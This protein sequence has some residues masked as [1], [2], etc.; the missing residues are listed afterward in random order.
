V[1]QLLQQGVVQ[2]VEWKLQGLQQGSTSSDSTFVK[3][4][5]Q[6]AELKDPLCTIS[7]VACHGARS[8]LGVLRLLKEDIFLLP[9]QLLRLQLQRIELAAK[10]K[11]GDSF[12]D[13]D[14]ED[15][16][17]KVSSSSAS[18]SQPGAAGAARAGQ[19]LEG[20]Q[21]GSD[22]MEES[23]SKWFGKYKRVSELLT[24]LQSVPAPHPTG[25]LLHSEAIKRAEA[26]IPSRSSM[27]V[28]DSCEVQLWQHI[29]RLKTGHLVGIVER[30]EED[31]RQLQ[32]Q[33]A[34]QRA[35]GRRL[36]GSLV[37]AAGSRMGDGGLL[38][39][40]HQVAT[41]LRANQHRCDAKAVRNLRQQLSEYREW[42]VAECK[43][44]IP[45]AFQQ[46]LWSTDL[47]SELIAAFR[48]KQGS[49]AEVWRKAYL[50]QSVVPLLWNTQDMHVLA[51][52]LAALW[53]IPEGGLIGGAT[54]L[55][56]VQLLVYA[57]LEAK[58]SDVCHQD[59]W[60]GGLISSSSSSR[61]EMRD[62]ALWRMRRFMRCFA[63]HTAVHKRLN[64]GPV[65]PECTQFGDLVTREEVLEEMFDTRGQLLQEA[66]EA[67]SSAAAAVAAAQGFPDHDKLVELCNMWQAKEADGSQLTAAGGRTGG[68]K[69]GWDPRKDKEFQKLARCFEAEFKQELKDIVDAMVEQQARVEELRTTGRIGILPDDEKA[70]ARAF[71][72]TYGSV[73]SIAAGA[74]RGH[75]WRLQQGQAGLGVGFSSAAVA[76]QATAA[77]Q[78]GQIG[79]KDWQAMEGFLNK[80]GDKTGSDGLGQRRRVGRNEADAGSSSRGSWRSSIKGAAAKQ[81]EGKGAGSRA[82]DGIKKGFFGKEK[83]K[84]GA[85][86]AAGATGGTSSSGGKGGVGKGD[87]A[88]RKQQQYE[89]G[90]GGG[91]AG[92]ACNSVGT[93]KSSSSSWYNLHYQP[94]SRAF[95]SFHELC[96]D[97]GRLP[98]P[99]DVADAM[100]RLGGAEEAVA[101][102]SKEVP[103][104]NIKL[105]L[106][107]QLVLL[108]AKRL[109]EALTRWGKHEEQQQQ[110]EAGRRKSWAAW[111]VGLEGLKAEVITWVAKCKLEGAD[112]ELAEQQGA[113]WGWW[114]AQALDLLPELLQQEKAHPPKQ[115]LAGAS[116]GPGGS[117]RSKDA[118]TDR[119]LLTLL[120]LLP[121][122]QQGRAQLNVSACLLKAV[123]Y[124]RNSG[125]A[126]AAKYLLLHAAE[127]GQLLQTAA[128]NVSVMA[129]D[130]N[131]P[132]ADVRP[133]SPEV[134]D[135]AKDPGWL[136]DKLSMLEERLSRFTV[137]GGA[138]VLITDRL[139]LE[140]RQSGQQH[141]QHQHK[142]LIQDCREWIKEVHDQQTFPQ[143]DTTMCL[144]QRWY[145]EEGTGT[146]GSSSSSKP[147]SSSA[148]G[149]AGCNGGASGRIASPPGYERWQPSEDQDFMEGWEK[150]KWTVWLEVLELVKNLIPYCP[151]VTQ[152]V[153]PRSVSRL[154]S[155]EGNSST[156][157]SWGMGMGTGMAASQLLRGQQLPVGNGGPGVDVEAT[158]QELHLG[159]EA[160]F[161]HAVTGEE[162]QWVGVA[163]QQ[164]L[165]QF[166][167]K[168]GKWVIH[169][170]VQAF[171]DQ[172]CS[173]QQELLIQQILPLKASVKDAKDE[174]LRDLAEALLEAV[175]L[176]GIGASDP[177]TGCVRLVAEHGKQALTGPLYRQLISCCLSNKVDLDEAGVDKLSLLRE[178]SAL[179]SPV[180]LSQV[181]QEDWPGDVHA[182][183]LLYETLYDFTSEAE[184]S[185]VLDRMGLAGSKQ[186]WATEKSSSSSTDGVGG[187][188]GGHQSR[189]GPGLLQ[190]Q[191]H[192]SGFGSLEKARL[193]RAEPGSSS[194]STGSGDFKTGLGAAA[195][196]EQADELCRTM[197]TAAMSSYG[198]VGN[199]LAE[200]AGVLQPMVELPSPPQ[201]EQQQQEQQQHQKQQQQRLACRGQPAAVLRPF[202]LKDLAVKGTS[203]K[204][205]QQ[206][207]AQEAGG[208]ASELLAK[209]AAGA[210]GQG[211]GAAPAADIA[212]GVPAGAMGATATTDEAAEAGSR[213]RSSS[214]GPS[215]PTTAAAAA[216]TSLGRG[217]IRTLAASS[218][219]VVASLGPPSHCTLQE[220]QERYRVL[221]KFHHAI[222]PSGRIHQIE[223]LLGSAAAL[224]L[225]AN[226][227]KV[228]H[229]KH[230]LRID[231]IALE[232]E[233]L[234]CFLNE[235]I[236]YEEYLASEG[237]AI[238]AN[239]A[240]GRRGV[241]ASRGGFDASGSSS[242]STGLVVG[243]DDVMR[244]KGG[245]GYSDGSSSEEEREQQQQQQQQP[246]L[247]RRRL[248]QQQRGA[249]QQEQQ[250][251]PFEELGNWE[252]LEEGGGLVEHY[253][254]PELPLPTLSASPVGLGGLLGCERDL[255][256]DTA[257]EGMK[258]LGS[259]LGYSGGGTYQ[260]DDYG[261]Y[262]GLESD[263]ASGSDSDDD[264]TLA[265]RAEEILLRVSSSERSAR[266][267]WQQEQQR[268]QKGE[269][270]VGREEEVTGGPS[271]QQSQRDPATAA[272][273]VALLRLWEAAQNVV[274]ASKVVTESEAALAIIG[275]RYALSHKG[276]NSVDTQLKGDQAGACLNHKEKVQ[277]EKKRLEYAEGTVRVREHWTAAM[278]GAAD[279]R[280]ALAVELR[281]LAYQRHHFKES[282][283]GKWAQEALQV[284]S[285]PKWPRGTFNDDYGYIGGRGDA[286][287]MSW[288]LTWETVSGSNRIR[289]R[290][291]SGGSRQLQHQPSVMWDE[292]GN[293]YLDDVGMVCKVVRG[294]EGA[295]IPDVL[296][297]GLS[298]RGPDQLPREIRRFLDDGR[299][300]D[301]GKRQA[302]F[303][304]LMADHDLQALAWDDVEVAKQQS[305]ACLLA[306]IQLLLR[307]G[308]L[309][310]TWALASYAES[311]S[312]ASSSESSSSWGSGAE[313]DAEYWLPS[314]AVA[315][316]TAT[317][318]AAAGVVGSAGSTSL[319][320]A[321][322]VPRRMALKHLLQDLSKLSRQENGK[323]GRAF[324]K[325]TV[326]HRPL[327][328]G[329]LCGSNCCDVRPSWLLRKQ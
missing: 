304:D 194:S 234:E 261:D 219:A 26:A 226:D 77:L 96:Q 59:R 85:G 243:E 129:G 168:L 68:G 173:R 107:Q 108:Q 90:G 153:T 177:A 287:R 95:D 265:Q 242:S 207:V 58:C 250:G 172:S 133:V 120:G 213:S 64:L 128:S 209:S 316:A 251:C 151:V 71:T 244:M 249:E 245:A 299:G 91:P 132:L 225:P 286:K 155:R 105:H 295:A 202:K 143:N 89:G 206:R 157:S 144:M 175:T 150:L 278:A 195:A 220:W 75:G 200:Q 305:E 181:P 204:S 185:A 33:A 217:E 51:L 253:T 99:E 116:R 222:G 112:K 162:G 137:L 247:R 189:E 277:L 60:D 223:Q 122:L 198:C 192:E 123:Y 35:G 193:M 254:A 81:Q 227:D 246:T 93:A 262:F 328:T 69:G 312:T 215:S 12:S 326:G 115:A 97:C 302:E 73:E 273:S 257:L 313:D 44:V 15:V 258:L 20:V 327:A 232:E 300:K 289:R 42:W 139:D 147:G 267:Q 121:V 238:D 274:A 103:V 125:P 186:G 39:L 40:L 86:A 292:E 187:G 236:P 36:K 102:A 92:G 83:Q 49:A 21:Q 48:G 25:V 29:A 263:D 23:D 54:L 230:V 191:G 197:P 293:G 174:D 178:G 307:T 317:A 19:V 104:D 74:E 169:E 166:G 141:Q 269:A 311:N 163:G 80:S 87:L 291:S 290:R 9:N 229:L 17:T 72:I 28:A 1:L 188:G 154:G 321:L 3:Q 281:Q 296:L 233:N 212:G 11:E 109:I 30:W 298:A 124:L 70:L 211:V 201:Q 275:E 46:A 65:R 171:W 135:A 259:N 117:Q 119:V 241:A 271:A 270:R 208:G 322:H 210:P 50:L 126:A 248:H 260:Y 16:L 82:S 315:S 309:Q 288:L 34:S 43:R 329:M 268:V 127:L 56:Y 323:V 148:I 199:G 113:F 22:G 190:Q 167:M 38:E 279:C 282:L 320:A 14:L 170:W 62:V 240:G 111:D 136:E 53:R 32:Q 13:S 114:E 4:Q 76:A 161:E 152:L 318:A 325:C 6:Q 31:V 84:R 283:G 52:L 67:S 27:S 252:L 110:Q 131:K 37:S 179:L 156:S 41:H 106:Q 10:A 237:R 297:K 63:A 276:L 284:S 94:L 142:Q 45:K 66:A 255:H 264:K 256:S 272:V 98:L 306:V 280:R 61:E 160:G 100:C 78:S 180:Y 308:L 146:E 57:A 239:E 101:A 196:A 7:Q 324:C 145:R 5:Q 294:P 18:T 118:A 8:F 88:P 164:V 159:S 216:R 235:D 310:E 301:A 47:E 218:P 138:A 231:R 319:G 303:Q 203:S 314:A 134:G 2:R 224:G 130:I 266:L 214:R 182:T 205:S 149:A 228:R 285:M 24:K 176:V 55:Q 158:L 183:A 184:G 165:Q 79:P 140:K 221:D